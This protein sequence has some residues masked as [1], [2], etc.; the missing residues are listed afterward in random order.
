MFLY[1]VFLVWVFYIKFFCIIKGI[2]D[3]LFLLID[4][5]VL[6]LLIEKNFV[7]EMNVFN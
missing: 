4:V 7:F 1:S 6:F 3:L 2:I 5:W